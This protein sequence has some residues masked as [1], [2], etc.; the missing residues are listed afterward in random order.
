MSDRIKDLEEDIEEFKRLLLEAER[1][2]VQ[3][4]LSKHIS[5]LK[6][7]LDNLASVSKSE[8]PVKQSPPPVAASS[9]GKQEIDK[10]KYIPLTKYAWDQEG[11]KVK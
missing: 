1:P 2:N 7:Q 11:P 5:S 9:T 3:N 6:T 4:F 8:E 10:T